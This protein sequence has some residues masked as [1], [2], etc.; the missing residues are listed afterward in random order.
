MFEK[1]RDGMAKKNLFGAGKKGVSRS[2][3]DL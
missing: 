2:A 1:L 3:V